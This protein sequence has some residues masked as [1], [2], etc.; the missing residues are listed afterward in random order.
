MWVLGGIQR[1]DN[2][3]CFLEVVPRRDAATLLPIIQRNVAPGTVIMS[4]SWRAYNTLPQLPEG[5]AH[6]AVNHSRNFVSPADRQVHTQNIEGMW[7]RIKR[8]HK[9]ISGQFHLFIMS[10]HNHVS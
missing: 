2:S 1:G 3:S 5:Y 6:Y 8:K 9:R 4:D 10:S 7:S